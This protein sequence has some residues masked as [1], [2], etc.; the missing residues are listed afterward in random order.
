MASKA[1]FVWGHFNWQ[2]APFHDRGSEEEGRCRLLCKICKS[3]LLVL[4][5]WGFCLRMAEV[6]NLFWQE[7]N[8]Y[9]TN[10]SD[11]FL[12][13]N[14]LMTDWSNGDVQYFYSSQNWTLSITFLILYPF[15]LSLFY[16]CR[17]YLWKKVFIRNLI[18]LPCHLCEPDPPSLP[19]PHLPFSLLFWYKQKVSGTQVLHISLP[20]LQ[21]DNRQQI[22]E[23]SI[24]PRY[25]KVA[26]R[27]FCCV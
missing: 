2:S 26:Q 17:L 18:G 5:R 27:W 15:S 19:F 11:L 24:H 9:F 3:R 23:K 16:R 13:N 1:V 10:F 21:A 8:Y 22:I 25:F 12:T 4:L 7:D 14:K 6:D 20:R